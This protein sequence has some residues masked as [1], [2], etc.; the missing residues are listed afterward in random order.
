MKGREDLLRGRGDYEEEEE[1][2]G[3][4]EEGIEV[5]VS[6]DGG[7]EQTS[8]SGNC[9]VVY[10]SIYL[11]IYLSITYKPINVHWLGSPIYYVNASGSRIDCGQI[12]IPNPKILLRRIYN[13]IYLYMYLLC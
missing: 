5:D 7:S 12:T 6:D 13:T 11:S 3:D 1:E 8:S 9:S 4:G 2:E 10:I